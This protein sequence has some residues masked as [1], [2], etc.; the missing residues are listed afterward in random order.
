M[1][2]SHKSQ[3]GLDHR[4]GYG[5][6]HWGELLWRPTG[7]VWQHAGV[8]WGRNLSCY[9]VKSVFL[10]QYIQHMSHLIAYMKHE[11]ATKIKLASC[12]SINIYKLG[13]NYFFYF[14]TLCLCWIFSWSRR[15]PSASRRLLDTF[16]GSWRS[17]CRTNPNSSAREHLDASSTQVWW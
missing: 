14:V 10:K 5:H 11:Q 6:C 17:H 2:Q 16:L 7:G 8:E 4:G 15:T 13:G 1:Y 9:K 3:W 12:H